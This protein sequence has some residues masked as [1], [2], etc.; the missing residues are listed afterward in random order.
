[1][2]IKRIL[3]FLNDPWLQINARLIMFFVLGFFGTYLTDYMW[4]H[5]FFAGGTGPWQDHPRY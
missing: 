3:T 5:G 1:M 2:S 4:E